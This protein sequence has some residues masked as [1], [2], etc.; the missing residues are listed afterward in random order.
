MTQLPEPPIP[1]DTD[2]RDL[3][4]FMLNTERLM[5][6]EL[7]AL[8]TGEEFKAALGLWCRAWKQTP[9]GSLPDDARVLAAFS[10]A[11]ARWNKVKAVALRGF[12]K[13]SDGRLYHEVLCEDVLRAAKK[14]AERHERTRAAT[15]A[16]KKQRDVVRNV[17]RGDE[18]NEVPWTGTG[19]GQGSITVPDGTVTARDA[20][21]RRGVELIAE[22]CKLGTIH[23][24]Q[25][26]AGLCKLHGDEAVETAL[27]ELF[28]HPKVE[29]RSWLKAA[30]QGGPNGTYR[31]RSDTRSAAGRVRASNPHA[32]DPE[33]DRYL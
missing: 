30:L 21:M 17:E 13:C 11:G 33:A 24:Q 16:R 2:I 6:S 26:V 29:P 18:R 7:W 15:E 20:C 8:S 25:F 10:G 27:T 4:G 31:E 19:Q 14:K 12:V 22:Q 1:A 3:D 28:E 23:A 9:P 32:P 5:A